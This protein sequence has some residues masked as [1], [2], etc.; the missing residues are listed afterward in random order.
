MGETTSAEE[1]KERGRTALQLG[2][3]EEAVACCDRGLEL[4]PNDFGLWGNRATALKR[5]GRLE[6]AL[7]SYRRA[8]ELNPGVVSLWNNM[9]ALLATAESMRRRCPASTAPWSSPRATTRR[10]ATGASH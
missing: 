8:A 4:T 1:W 6:E 2:Q 10:G 9:G 3:H 7:A 5:L